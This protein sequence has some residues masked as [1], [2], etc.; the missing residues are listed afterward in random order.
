MSINP[1]SLPREIVQIR[2]STGDT[3][4]TTTDLM[5]VRK[6]LDP[7]SDLRFGL[8]PYFYMMM[9]LKNF[10]TTKGVTYT[11]I[12]RIRALI[13]ESRNG[14]PPM[15]IRIGSE[16]ITCSEE[17]LTSGRWVSR[18]FTT[19]NYLGVVDVSVKSFWDIEDFFIDVYRKNGIDLDTEEGP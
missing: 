17:G 4:Y 9:N 10:Q 2:T 15:S 11:W 18:S 1:K 12:P 3:G 13:I 16:N 8:I 5:L 6:H 14:N 19:N 7:L